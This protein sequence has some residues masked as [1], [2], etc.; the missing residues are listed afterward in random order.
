MITDFL[1]MLCTVELTFCS[2]LPP[3]E[4]DRAFQ[5]LNPKNQYNLFM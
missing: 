5:L 4:A 3:V 1:E 2:A